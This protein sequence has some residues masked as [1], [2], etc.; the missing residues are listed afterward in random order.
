MATWRPLRDRLSRVDSAVTIS[1]Q[2]LDHLVGGLPRSA[3]DH[4]AFWSGDRSGWPGFRA[5]D[6]RVGHSVTFERTRSALARPALPHS[7]GGAPPPHRTFPEPRT[8]RVAAHPNAAATDVLLIGCVKQK[9]S[10]AAAAQDLYVSPLFRKG[11]RHAERLGKPW[12]VLSAQH[13]LVAPTDVLDPYD[14]RLSKTSSEYRRVWGHRVIEAL[15]AKVGPLAGIVVEIHAGAAYVDAVRGLL[16]SRGAT[17]VEPLAGLPLGSR[18]AWYGARGFSS[19]AARDRSTPASGGESVPLDFAAVVEALRDGTRAVTTG[20]LRA[21]TG[22]GLRQA[23]IYSWWVDAA[24]ADD[25]SLGL[26]HRVLPG[27]VYAGTAGATRARSGMPSGNTLWGRIFSMHLGGRHEFST[28]R[29]TLGSIL[30]EAHGWE[31]IDEEA[32]TTWMDDH[33]RVVAVPTDPS[34]LDALETQV[35]AALDPPL[36]LAK[37]ASNPLRKRLSHLRSGHRS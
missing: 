2:E 10:V 21:T 35:L 18:L 23:G 3:Y 30:A 8:P 1:W 37:V 5:T 11:R 27:L 13:G 34:R 12:F 32:L 28:F 16:Q 20:Q 22:A 14:L 7:G 17:V 29:R 26:G 4:R 19:G 6:V 24:G 36:N 33:L 9:L 31:R 15:E 25:L